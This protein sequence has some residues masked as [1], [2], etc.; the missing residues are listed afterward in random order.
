MIFSSGLTDE[1][2]EA[3]LFYGVK[4]FEISH[5]KKG[6]IERIGKN[7]MKEIN[8]LLNAELFESKEFVPFDESKKEL[9]SGNNKIFVQKIRFER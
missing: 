5:L 9:F 2:I 1:L 8:K 6:T 4:P 7:R 3:L